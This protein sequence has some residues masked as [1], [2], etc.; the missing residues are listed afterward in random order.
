V[1]EVESNLV[2]LQCPPP[3]QD[4]LVANS[5]LNV[6]GT[7]TWTPAEG[8][9]HAELIPGGVIDLNTSPADPQTDAGLA[10]GR[11]SA[12]VAPIPTSASDSA[13]LAVSVVRPDGLVVGMTIR[14]FV[15]ETPG[16][17]AP[18]P[19]SPTGALPTA[20]Q[21]TRA[22]ILHAVLRHDFTALG[23]LAKPGFQYGQGAAGD[24]VGYWKRQGPEVFRVLD[25]LLHMQPRIGAAAGT[26]FYSWPPIANFPHSFGP[27][28]F[29]VLHVL[30]GGTYQAHLHRW[31]NTDRYTGWH[32][33]ID[34]RGRWVEF[35]GP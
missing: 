31:M 8:H 2:D 17:S 24:P 6:C 13:I 1:T 7:A 4:F 14:R 28:S 3:G 5:L 19:P 12:V 29:R 23:R 32:L 35:V 10:S 27:V 18:S 25:L 11:Y 20:V 34:D 33:M 30:Y 9:V 16:G 26:T 22:A 15:I 21:Q